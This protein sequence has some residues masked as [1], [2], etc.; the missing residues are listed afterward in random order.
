MSF[1]GII[2]NESLNWKTHIETIENKISKNL[3]LLYKAKPFL[4]LKCLKQ[5]YFSF[6]HSYLNYCNIAWA[7]TY[8]TN[9][10]RLYSKQKHACRIM[11]GENRYTSVAHRLKEIGA[12]DIFQLNACQILTF[13]YKVK[14]GLCPDLFKTKFKEIDHKYETRYSKDAYKIPNAILDTKRFSIRY[15]GPRLWNNL[16]SQNLKTETSLHTF[17]RLLKKFFDR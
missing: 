7:S 8:M 10:K 4:N 14:N 6:I 16:L 17:R 3:G 11:F 9:I 12:L 15:R 1:L 2:F 5:L 13:M